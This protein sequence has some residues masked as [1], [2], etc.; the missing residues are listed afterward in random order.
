MS[1]VTSL[2]CRYAQE[3]PS[4]KQGLS[5]A[6]VHYLNREKLGVLDHRVVK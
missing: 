6:E 3:F 2:Y 1:L 4:P 5:K